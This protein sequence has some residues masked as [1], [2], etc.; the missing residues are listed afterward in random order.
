MRETTRSRKL[1]HSGEARITSRKQHENANYD[2]SPPP[3][4][5][6]KQKG[7]M[8]G[9]PSACNNLA[10]AWHAPSTAQLYGTMLFTTMPHLGPHLCGSMCP[11]RAYPPSVTLGTKSLRLCHHC[12]LI[13]EGIEQ[14]R[15]RSLQHEDEELLGDLARQ[16]LTRLTLDGV[17]I[18]S[19]SCNAKAQIWSESHW[20]CIASGT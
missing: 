10:T 6:R 11:R 2:E 5:V 9:L 15:A 13:Q 7:V 4:G 14:V 12:A 16:E 20:V 3:G 17:G 8:D 1:A 18:H 19:S